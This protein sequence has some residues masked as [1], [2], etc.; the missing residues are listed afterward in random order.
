MSLGSRLPYVAAVAPA[1][2]CVRAVAA[3][4]PPR[5]PQ[6]F[7]FRAATLPVTPFDHDLITVASADG[8]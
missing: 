3:A 1:W 2:P 6:A 8:K 4:A 5:A 7:H